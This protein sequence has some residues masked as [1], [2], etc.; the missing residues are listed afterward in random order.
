MFSTIRSIGTAAKNGAVSLARKGNMFALALAAAG[1]V[2]F[3]TTSAHAE[4]T[5]PAN[6]IA[7]DDYASAGMVVVGQVLGA[8]AG[9]VIVVSLVRMGLRRLSS[10][11][12]G[13]A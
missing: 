6:P 13:R 10:A 11:F 1:Y 7:F 4:V 2:A 12:S 5:L 3:S 9:I 8:I